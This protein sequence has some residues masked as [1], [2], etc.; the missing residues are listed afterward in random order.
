M[1]NRIEK[2]FFRVHWGGKLVEFEQFHKDKYN[3]PL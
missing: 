3:L 1:E 2:S